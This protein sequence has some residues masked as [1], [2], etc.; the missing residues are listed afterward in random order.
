MSKLSLDALKQRA[1]SVA[2][3]D[4]LKSISGGIQN[5]CHDED[6]GFWT[7]VKSAIFD[8]ISTPKGPW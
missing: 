6:G 3:E 1:D 8:Y 4:L 2:T 7:A 5:A